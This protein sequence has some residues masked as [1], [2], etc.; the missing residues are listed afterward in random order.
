ME[1]EIIGEPA[2]KGIHP[3]IVIV[4]AVLL[5]LPCFAF[6][7]MRLLLPGDASNPAIDFSQTSNDGLVISPL[8]PGTVGLQPGDRVIAIQ[9]RPVDAYFAGLFRNSWQQPDG[10]GDQTVQYTAVRN[11]Q[12]EQ[13]TTKLSSFPLSQAF[14]EGWSIYIFLAYLEIVS[15]AIF[16]RRPR[17][18][19]SQLFVFVCTLI[20]ASGLMFYP[21]LLVDELLRGPAALLYIWGEVILFGIM[22]A[23]LVLLPLNFPSQNSLLNRRPGLA[24]GI[25]LGI[26][27]PYLLYLVIGWPAAHG[28]AAR[29]ALLIN[30]ATP[31]SAVGFLALLFSTTY[32]YRS[33]RSEKERRQLRWI[34]WGV[35]IANGPYLALSILPTLL[36]IPYQIGNSLVGILWCAVPTSI[37]IAIF[38][39]RLFDIDVIIRRTIIYGVLTIAIGAIYF[40]SVVLLQEIFQA[41]TGQHQP[42]LAIVLSTLAIA[43]LFNPLRQRIQADIDRR[44]YRRK[45]NAEKLL[46]AFASRVRNE[47]ELEQLQEHLLEIVQETMQPEH[48]SLWLSSKSGAGIKAI[49]TG[50]E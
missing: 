40:G 31:M 3:A 17:L 6:L 19:A 37:A 27:L 5:A 41:F 42:P 22:L 38:H 32:A 35:F 15:L 1:A 25:F 39:E 13:V 18:A 14:R 28:P 24:P 2:G 16:I 23:G 50:K 9:G 47:V 10:I 30:S 44:F 26:W 34:L 11:G 49:S 7:A 4:A 21:G 12:P 29:Y 43:A 48:A 45:Y 20:F 36:G 46:Q 8:A 33:N